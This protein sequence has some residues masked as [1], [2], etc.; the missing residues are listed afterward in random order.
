MPFAHHASQ[1]NSNRLRCVNANQ[2]GVRHDILPRCNKLLPEISPIQA[3][4]TRRCAKVASQFALACG[5]MGDLQ[6]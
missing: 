4:P 6:R 1:I 2:N 3:G 5:E